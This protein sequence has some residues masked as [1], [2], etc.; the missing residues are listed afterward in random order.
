MPRPGPGA[1]EGTRDLAPLR[2]IYQ[3]GDVV[4]VD[5]PSGL[6]VHPSD[7]ATDRV[8]VLQL[9]RDATGG[10]H[11]Y[12]V[13][14]LDRGSSG[15]LVLARSSAA[16]SGLHAQLEEGHADKRY[17][18]AV[19]GAPA[20]AGVID[21]PIPRREGGPRVPARTE[22]RRVALATLALPGA[23]GPRPQP[24]ALVEA[25]PRS[26]RLHQI[27]RHLKHIGHPVLGDANYGR[28]EHNRFCRDRFG[29]DRLALHATSLTFDHP[30][31]GERLTLRAPLPPDLSQPLLRMGLLA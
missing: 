15:V 30:R 4:V 1:G 8:T 3:D 2:I 16:A 11:L 28:G 23:G 9:A 7:Q 12:P 25:R 5:K 14:R 6:L 10:A 17:L 19:R 20:E 13:H 21:H 26:G 31:T 18:A 27:R 29:L 22:F 24:Y